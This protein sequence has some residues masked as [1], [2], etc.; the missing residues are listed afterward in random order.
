MIIRL[1][2]SGPPI[3]VLTPGDLPGR[4]VPWFRD[5]MASRQGRTYVAPTPVGPIE[6]GD[7]VAQLAPAIVTAAEAA[8]LQYMSARFVG[9]VRADVGE[10]EGPWSM[11]ADLRLEWALNGGAWQRFQ[12]GPDPSFWNGAQQL[13]VP[14]LVAGDLPLQVA[15]VLEGTQ[16][17][18]LNSLAATDQITIRCAW[19]NGGTSALTIQTTEEGDTGGWH[20]SGQIWR[21]S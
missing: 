8:E 16:L 11:I 20:L 12:R 4:N 2:P 7:S 6:D 18:P 9:C 17:F 15:C 13:R 19:G 3:D 1:A 10:G 14:G 21:A 5:Q